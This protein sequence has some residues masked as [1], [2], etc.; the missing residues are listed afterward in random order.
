VDLA[1]APGSSDPGLI[2]GVCPAGV[3]LSASAVK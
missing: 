1:L 3:H 2:A